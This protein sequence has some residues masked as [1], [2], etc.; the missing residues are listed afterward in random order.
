MDGSEEADGLRASAAA[1]AP[2]Q[3][4]APPPA[5]GHRRRRRVPLAH[6]IR[7]PQ[8]E[9][10]GGL[11]RVAHCRER[12]RHHQHARRVHTLCAHLQRRLIET[13]NYKLQ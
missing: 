6:R 10:G 4:V 8:V 5:R 13:I 2:A 3:P 9:R 7:G 11:T 12:V 1:S